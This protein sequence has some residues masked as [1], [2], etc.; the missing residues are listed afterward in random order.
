MGALHTRSNFLPDILKYSVLID[1]HV[2]VGLCSFAGLSSHI[3]TA[4]LRTWVVEELSTSLPGRLHV[5]VAIHDLPLTL[6]YKT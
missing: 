2:V 4:I 3:T 5:L 6:K 1:R